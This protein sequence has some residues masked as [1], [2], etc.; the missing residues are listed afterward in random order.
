MNDDLKETQLRALQYQHVDGTFELT[1]GGV[2]LLNA[3]CSYGVSRLEIFNPSL[4]NGLLSF[5]PLLVFIGGALLIDALVQRFRKRVTFPRT[6]YI[7][8]QKPQTLKRSTRLIIWIGI[9]ILTVI[10]VVLLFL[11]RSKFPMEQNQD[12]VGNLIPGFFGLV[13]GGLYAIM[14]WK[15]AL[16]RF[17]LIALVSLLVGAWLFVSGL[18][19]YLGMAFFFGVMGL[20]L[21]ISGGVTL[22]RY[23][24]DTPSPTQEGPK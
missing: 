12:Y 6:G 9:P 15:I 17:Y 3:A 16:S 4:A 10:M 24:L 5:A 13:F 14:G 20:S 8:Y 18:P 7:A 19:T 1:F 22:W 11:N 21:C 23:L 2:F